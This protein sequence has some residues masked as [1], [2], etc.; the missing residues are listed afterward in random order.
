MARATAW[1]TLG[2]SSGDFLLLGKSQLKREPSMAWPTRFG[3]TLIAAQSL[4]G[5]SLEKFT[6]P[7]LTALVSAVTS[8][9]MRYSM[10]SK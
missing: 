2:L 7:D 8:E 1:R 3:S 5:I 4:G 6:T 9:M 10:A